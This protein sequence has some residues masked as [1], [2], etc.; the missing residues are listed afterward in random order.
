MS[1]LLRMNRRIR[2]KKLKK[3]MDYTFKHSLKT[4]VLFL[5][6]LLLFLYGPQDYYEITRKRLLDKYVDLTK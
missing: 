4:V 5:C 2:K 3:D 1:R 6:G